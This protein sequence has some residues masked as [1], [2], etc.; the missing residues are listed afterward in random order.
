MLRMGCMRKS[1]PSVPC[2]QFPINEQFCRVLMLPILY[3][4]LQ[5][6]FRVAYIIGTTEA[7]N[8]HLIFP[9]NLNI[10]QCGHKHRL[11]VAEGLIC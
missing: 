4:T 6:T 2:R 8:I 1:T 5:Q 10:S 11:L 7:L 9:F 3:A